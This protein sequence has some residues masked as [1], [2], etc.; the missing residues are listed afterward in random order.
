MVSIHVHTALKNSV[1]GL[2]YLRVAVSRGTVN[3]VLTCLSGGDVG[4]GAVHTS[5]AVVGS[6]KRLVESERSQIGD[7]GRG[8]ELPVKDQRESVVEEGD[9][10]G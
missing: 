1:S 6:H 8:L 7:S 5:Y 10:E 3:P 4:C 2:S 9:P